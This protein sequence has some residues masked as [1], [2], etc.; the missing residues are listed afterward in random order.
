MGCIGGCVDTVCFFFVNV[1]VWMCVF[2]RLFECGCMDVCVL[3][4]CEDV[5]V[6]MCVFCRYV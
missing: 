6:W 4:I 1:G 5:G 3:F 2:V